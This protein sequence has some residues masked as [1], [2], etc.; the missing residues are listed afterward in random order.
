MWGLCS[1]KWHFVL[2]K[3]CVDTVQ[4][5]TGSQSELTLLQY[6]NDFVVIQYEAG[7]IKSKIKVETM[8]NLW[9]IV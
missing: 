2:D 6:K 3:I 5:E 4:C 7:T 8:G 9:I 1:E